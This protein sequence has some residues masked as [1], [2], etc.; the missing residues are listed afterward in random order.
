[1][2]AVKDSP[3]ATVTARPRAITEVLARRDVS[4]GLLLAGML[5]LAYVAWF[6][7]GRRIPT[8]WI[9]GDELLYSDM[10][11]SYHATG[12]YE[13][14]DIPYD[15]KTIYPALVSPAWSSNS[16]ASAYGAAKAIN[17]ALMTA[18]AIP[19]YFWARRLV[20]LPLAFLAVGLMLLLPSYVYSAE[21]MTENAFL[22][23]FMLAA[24]LFALALERPTLLNQVLTLGA[25]GL[26]VSV[27]LQGAILVAIVPAA[28]AVKLLLD[29]AADR[30]SGRLRYLWERVRALWLLLGAVILGG[31]AY[32]AYEAHN[33]RSLTSGLGAYQAVGT[34][35][36]TLHETARWAVYHVAELTFAVGVIPVCALVVLVGLAVRRG[37]STP[38]ERALLAITLAAVPLVCIQVG[39][40]ASRFSFRI[41]ER[42]MFFLEPL[43]VLAFVV[44]LARGAPRP[45]GLATVAAVIP[46]G[47]MVLLPLESLFGVQLVSD[48]FGLVPLYRLATDI[49]GGATDT[50]ILFGLG[51]LAAGILFAAT[52]KRLAL[53]ILAGAVTGF[54]V[55]SSL[56]V[57]GMARRQSFA[58]RAA[59]GAGDPEWVD[60]AVGY[61]AK[62]G[63]V[64]TQTLDNPHVLWQ[65]E[66]WNRSVGP[67]MNV[68]APQ[69]TLGDTTTLNQANGLLTPVDASSQRD[70]DVTYVVADA[71]LDIA[72]R[73]VGETSKLKLWKIQAPLRIAAYPQGI[74]ADGWTGAS[75][76]VTEYAAPGDRPGRVAVRLDR[77]P[78][79]PSA[80]PATVTVTLGP[81]VLGPN[82]EQNM[83]SVTAKKTV[84]VTTKHP[85]TVRLPTPKPPYR[86]NV[87]V[88]PTFDAAQLGQGDTRQLGAR[89]AL[90]QLKR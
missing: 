73:L 3:P 13:F 54:L 51:A 52:P 42:N 81:F 9:M 8:P 5:V 6:I 16:I 1:V 82:G 60:H 66:F 39:A 59:S 84:T 35:N 25:I 85:V 61:D 4:A 69:A 56:A 40:F 15:L 17:V 74:D 47:L 34:V 23:A 11:K 24:F 33:G 48:T 53:P 36:Y 31:L 77:V 70:T 78:L 22:P 57:L 55:L 32:A 71:N 75:A 27:R 30:P 87:N 19:A 79:G 38:A 68:G 83:S 65:T 86:V 76:G 29:L 46:V 41:E 12:H 89:V 43:L 49:S 7:A 90:T 20:G 64:N 45:Q 58:T 88:T 62:V 2:G 21:V 37:W 18:A 50:R 14:R 72:G 67:V 28:I 26:V 80:P 10:A 63:Y 44:W